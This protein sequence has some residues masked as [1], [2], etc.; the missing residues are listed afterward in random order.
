[1]HRKFVEPQKKPIK[2]T[3]AG[4]SPIIE[5]NPIVPIEPTQP[6]ENTP[7]FAYAVDFACERGLFKSA[8]KPSLVCALAK[9]KEEDAIS[10]WRE[11][12]DGVHTRS[13]ASAKP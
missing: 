1:M 4:Y 13:I 8:V 5:D 7:A 3:S 12:A 2:Q 10:Q 9:T 11:V 6:T